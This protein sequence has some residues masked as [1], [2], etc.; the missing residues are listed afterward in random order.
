[1]LQKEMCVFCCGACSYHRESVLVEHSVCTE[2]FS[3]DASFLICSLQLDE[4]PSEADTAQ[5][6]SNAS[7]M[8]SAATVSETVALRGTTTPVLTHV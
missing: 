6:F 1:M 2:P 3:L 8:P 4:L 7:K 5:L